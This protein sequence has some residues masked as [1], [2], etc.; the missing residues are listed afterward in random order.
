M[1][2]YEYENFRILVCDKRHVP[3]FI[4]SLD[5][6]DISPVGQRPSVSN[7]V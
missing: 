1:K 6:D 3:S 7:L 5:F 2:M 4:Y